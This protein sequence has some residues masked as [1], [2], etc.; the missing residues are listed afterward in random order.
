MNHWLLKSDPDCYNFTSLERDKRTVWDGVT[1]AQAQQFIRQ[2]KKGDRALIYHTGNEKSIIGLADVVSDAYPDP[3]D[4]SGKLSVVDLKAG[5]RLAQPVSLAS[6]KADQA[7]KDFLL[8]RHSRLSV[9]PV[10]EMLWD[11]LRERGGW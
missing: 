11:L 8:V 4:K 7:F 9:M 1:N 2:M 5:K 3:A 10:P 6:I